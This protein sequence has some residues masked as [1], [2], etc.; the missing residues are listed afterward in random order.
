MI[1]L[2]AMLIREVLFRNTTDANNTCRLSISA[3]STFRIR[4]KSRSIFS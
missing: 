2:V 4:S 3:W 1:R